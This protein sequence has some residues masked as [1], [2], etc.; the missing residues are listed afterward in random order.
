M[1]TAARACPACH[2]PLPEEAQ[3]C[4]RCG[5]ATPTDP[6]VPQRTATTCMVEITQVKRALAGRYQIERV[7]G[8]GGMAT[9]YLAH[10]Q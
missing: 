2:T 7:L 3:F 5:V 10:D 1:T 9:V 6:G 4:L 8:E